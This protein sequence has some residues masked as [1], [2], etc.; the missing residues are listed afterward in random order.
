M[1]DAWK[2]ATMGRRWKDFLDYLGNQALDAKARQ[3][4]VD[5]ARS[6]FSCFERWLD[7]Q[8]VLL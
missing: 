5:A 3:R 4:A 2:W 1:N 6:T 7:S 8:E